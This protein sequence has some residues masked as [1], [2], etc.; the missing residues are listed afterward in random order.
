METGPWLKVSSDRMVKPGIEP[1]TPGLQGKQLIHHTT[2][3]PDFFSVNFGPEE[4]ERLKIYTGLDK[5]KF[6][7]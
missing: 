7:A 5:Q 2:A 6:S 1:A 3:A 4:E